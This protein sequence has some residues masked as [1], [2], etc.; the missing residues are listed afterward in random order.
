[1]A[2]YRPAD[3][4]AR[5]VVGRVSARTEGPPDVSVV[6]PC[7]NEA[8][9]LG[10]LVAELARVLDDLCVRAEVLFVD[11]AS[12][13]SSLETLRRLQRSEPRLRVLSHRINSG[14]SAAQAT[15]FRHSRGA[16]VVTMDS[17]GQNDPADIPALLAALEDADVACGVRR[18]RLDDRVR[19]IS[20]RVANTFRNAVT[21][22]RIQDAG[23]TYRAI[24]REAL[25]EVPV[26]NGMH[27]FL[28]TLLRLQGFRVVEVPVGHRP[29]RAGE[30]KYGVHDRLWRG[31][32]DCLAMLWWRRRVVPGAR[33]GS[34]AIGGTKDGRTVP[35]PVAKIASAR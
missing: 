5:E 7:F 28:P 10:A 32:F 18:R 23:C 6:L 16:C 34:D 20:S 24:R 3:F 31:L 33:I 22:D 17:D 2:A 9:N 15:G 21:G 19:R 11:D 12:T 29:R 35:A 30:S 4:A 26:F 25:Q 27:R 14:E 13:D 8:G 1:M